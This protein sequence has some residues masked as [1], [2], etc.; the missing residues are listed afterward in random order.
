MNWVEIERFKTLM[1]TGTTSKAA[2]ALGVTQPAVSQSIARLQA[3]AGF[4][5]FE[6]QGNRLLPRPEAHALLQEVERV[7][8]GMASVEHKL[9]SLKRVGVNQLSI[10]SYPALGFGFLP[11]ALQRYAHELAASGAVALPELSL[12][13]LSSR[14]VL[15]QVAAAQVDFGLMADEM[16]FHGV[17]HSRLAE[18][19]AVLVLPQTHPLTR[20]KRVRALDLHGQAFVALNP[21]DAVR[22]RLDA[23]LS[24]AGARPQV[25]AQT[26]YSASVCE[27][28]AAGW[29]VGVANPITAM[30][31]MG[32][33]LAIRPLAFGLKFACELVLPPSRPL[34]GTAQ[35]VLVAIRRQLELDQAAIARELGSS[36]RA[37][38]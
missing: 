25:V 13:V 20:C 18:F 5:L 14:E 27:L 30:A 15:A 32:R 19:E 17:V 24:A 29:G 28:V 34:S 12:Q 22:K 3:Q 21:E 7:F 4:A 6:K 31:H 26:P 10:A 37:S 36:T 9:R 33:G 38:R 35:A 8:V 2:A 23:Q 1:V 11:R 16:D